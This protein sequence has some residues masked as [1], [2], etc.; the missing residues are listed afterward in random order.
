MARMEPL[1]VGCGGSGGKRGE[2]TA[3]LSRVG[4]TGEMF[5][6]RITPEDLSA[7]LSALKKRRPS[8]LR[9]VAGGVCVWVGGFMLAALILWFIK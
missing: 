8:R 5:T 7:L 3:S 2:S 9:R 1:G 6:Y 4:N